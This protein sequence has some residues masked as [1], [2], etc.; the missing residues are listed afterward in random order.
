MACI[1]ATPEFG[2]WI[3][4]RLA[5]DAGTDPGGVSDAS[6]TA[7]GNSEHHAGDDYHTGTLQPFRIPRELHGPP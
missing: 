2:G 6:S 4:G 3:R 5:G 1:F 7:H